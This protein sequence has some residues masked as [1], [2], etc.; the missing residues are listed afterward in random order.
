MNKTSS[1]EVSWNGAIVKILFIQNFNN[2]LKL[3][4]QN[5]MY[6]FGL[7]IILILEIHIEYVY[8]EDGMKTNVPLRGTNN[9]SWYLRAKW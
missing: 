7:N 2:P 8:L 3:G 4:N 9:P 1:E 5:N 6:I